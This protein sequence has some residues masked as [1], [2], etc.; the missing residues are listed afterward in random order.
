[1][2]HDLFDFYGLRENPFHICPDPRFY[3]WTHGHSTALTELTFG[4]ETRQGV[5]V[6]TGEV[7][8]GKTTLLH[9][10]LNWL[11]ARRQSSCY[12][13]H[14]QLKPV[15]LF[16]LILQ[17]FGVPCNSRRKSDL[18]ATLKQW[19]VKRHSMGDS[20]VIIL[21]EAQSISLRTLDRLR[22]LL[23]LEIPGSKLL[24]IVLAGQPELVEKLRRPELRQL[25]QRIMF[26]CNLVPLSTEETSGYVRSRL[27][28]SGAKDTAVFSDESLKA[29]HAYA[30]GIPRVVNLLCEHALLAGYAKKLP[31]ITPEVIL[32]VAAEFGLCSPP[33]TTSEQEELPRFRQLVPFCTEESTTRIMPDSTP[34]V[35]QAKMREPVAT[36]TVQKT[37][38]KVRPESEAARLMVEESILL[39]TTPAAKPPRK[40]PVREYRPRLGETFARYWRSVG[41]SFVRDWKRFLQAYV[42]EESGA[43]FSYRTAQLSKNLQRVGT[44]VKDL[45]VFSKYPSDRI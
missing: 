21:D 38:L 11:R 33:A 28:N 15:E 17:D 14:S 12:I 26:R 7:G 9:H 19:L 37:S 41:K 45:I 2:Y 32:R 35:D 44:L 5:I 36:V 8:T 29:V 18:L 30:R 34:L 25:R 42:K 31:V 10:F 22:M 43:G 27:T 13:F 3:F 20:P 4:I 6:L 24:Q 16:E 23:N 40:L 1:M 39:A